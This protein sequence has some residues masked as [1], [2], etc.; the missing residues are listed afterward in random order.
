MSKSYRK[1][2]NKKYALLG[3]GILAIIVL[4]T[5]G[6]IFWWSPI[7]FPE[8]PA[9]STF[10][11]RSLVDREDVSDWVELSIWIPDEDKTFD[12]IEDYQTL[13]NFEETIKSKHAEDISIDLSD[14][15]MF[16]VEV[17]TSASVW[18]NTFIRYTGGTNRHYTIE[19]IDLSS[20]VNF[21]IFDVTTMGTIS[22]GALDGNY[23]CAMDIPHYNTADSHS[24]SNWEITASDVDDM[25][26]EELED[27]YDERNYQCQAPL[28]NPADDSIKD[29]DDDLEKITDAFAIR[30]TFN[31]SISKVDG[32]AT[33][34]NITL[35]DS[36]DIELAISGEYA[37]FIFID[38]LKFDT[39]I[40]E[41]NFECTTAVNIT[42]STAQSGR[43][44][45]PYDD[46]NLG[47]FTA[48][49][50]IGA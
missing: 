12:D 25:T 22:A 7:L 21:N 8:E 49:S 20:D 23:S 35:I 36:D 18:S 4:I 45:T 50:T 26:T 5:L 10:E 40:Q 6:S 31:D 17:Q 38:V 13:S 1:G 32:E 9:T 28:Y 48:Y 27:L 3:L 41:F 16:W 19:A 42:Y 11:V 46:D 29:W 47:T 15:S 39:G 14:V 2:S 33:Q 44:L 24:G 37:Y 43:V 30:L 34:V